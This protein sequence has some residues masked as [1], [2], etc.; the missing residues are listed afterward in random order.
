MK[1]KICVLGS[2]IYDC[3][4][5]ADH[6]PKKGETVRG[7]RS[8]FFPGGKGANQAVQAS[9]MGAQTYMIGCV[10]TDDTGEYL[11]KELAQ[12]GISV[13]HITKDVHMPTSVCAIHVDKN[14]DNTIVMAPQA[15]LCIQTAD[16]DAAKDVIV[17]MDVFLTQLETNYNVIEY[18]LQLAKRSGVTTVLNPAPP[19]DIDRTVFK[20]ADYVTPNETEAEYF[21]GIYRDDWPLEEWV[22]RCAEKFMDMGAGAVVITMGEKGAAFSDGKKT[23]IFPAYKIVAVDSTAAG[24]A[25]NGAFAYALAQNASI[26]EAV[27]MACAAGALTAA[28][29]GAQ[30]SIP[31]KKE[32][33]ALMEREE[34]RKQGCKTT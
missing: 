17:S 1:P 33:Q 21:T 25:F 29:V 10:G 34:E 20:Y 11:L 12:N 8:G 16:I 13:A 9:R 24:D 15:N 4:L 26:Q 22:Q 31:Y 28:G 14:G 6:L 23:T 30:P 5:W 2:L 18:A 7:L 3:V 19:G 27:R 32:I